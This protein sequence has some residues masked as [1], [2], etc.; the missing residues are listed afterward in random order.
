MVWKHR[1]L[2]VAMWIGLTSAA[3]VGLRLWP[4]VYRSETLILVDSQKIP[5]QFVNSTVSSE[6]QDRLATLSQQILSSTRLQK[7]IDTFHLYEKKQ[8]THTREEILVKMRKDINITL[9]K[10]WAKDRPGAFRISYEAP[11]AQ[12]AAD[13]ANQLGS[14]FVE[15]NLRAREVQAQG[16]SEFFRNQ[17]AEAKKTLDELEEK[18]SKYKLQHNGELPQQ[19]PTLIST[20]T[21]VQIE[22]EGNQNALNRAEQQKTMLESA[23]TVAEVSEGSLKRLVDELGV[24]RAD[25][26]RALPAI[27]QIKQD[28]EL[29]QA[30]LDQL[31]LKYQ[32]E[33]PTIKV[34]K[35]QLEYFQRLEGKS[36]EKLAESQFG[37]PDEGAQE[38]KFSSLSPESQRA[39]S[40]ERERVAT[41]KSQ[42]DVA[43]KEVSIRQEEHQ[44]ILQKIAG[45]Q[46]RLE[47][48]PLREQEL[49]GVTRDYEI[50]KAHYMSLLNK[51]YAVDMAADMERRQKAE[52]FTVLDPARLPEKPVAPNRPLLGA[53]SC[54]AALAFSTMLVLGLELKK[55]VLLGDWELP[56]NIPILGRVPIVAVGELARGKG[57]SQSRL[58]T[59]LVSSGCLLGFAVLVATGIH[60]WVRI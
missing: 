13:V 28:R 3:V 54:L 17:L 55:N 11:T 18:V 35:A 49:A 59:A 9:E 51:I 60:F 37:V 2:L 6:L 45:Y 30:Q 57:Q 41:L 46:T 10:G 24:R 43:R 38:R 42:L 34:L 39:L 25:G 52:R 32:E 53:V 4:N 15:E 12:V 1:L 56:A 50:S 27:S 7:I 23:V 14:L 29:V 58:R 40:Q 48:L 21:R 19:E 47:S 26:P 33:H 31:R 22:L 16:T 44:Q 20:L 36:T 5:E 8:V